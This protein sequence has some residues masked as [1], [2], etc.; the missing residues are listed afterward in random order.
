[1]YWP[2]TASRARASGGYAGTGLYTLGERGREFVLNAET[3]RRLEGQ[4][5]GSL[6]QQNVVN[7][8][9]TVN[10]TFAGMGGNDR[11]WFEA[12]LQDFGRDLARM[13]EAA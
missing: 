4:L 10:A 8:G 7:R 2:R 6:T 1:M 13:L 9:L 5:G 11:A 12:R 3:T